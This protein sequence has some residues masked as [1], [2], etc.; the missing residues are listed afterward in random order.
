MLYDY[1]IPADRLRLAL[2]MVNVNGRRQ[3][4]AIIGMRCG[5]E[6]RAQLE[7]ELTDAFQAR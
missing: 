6:A 4:L 5:P 3:V 2:S 1:A 7:R